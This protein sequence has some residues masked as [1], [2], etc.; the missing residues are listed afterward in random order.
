MA[1]RSASMSG[2]AS[3]GVGGRHDVVERPRAPLAVRAGDELLAVSGGQRRVRQQHGVA[4]GG[5]QP[6]VPPP[7]PGIPAAH[8]AAVHPKQQ[9]RL[10]VRRGGLGQHQPGPDRVAVV[11][12]RLDLLEPARHR[13]RDT[14]A[15]KRGRAR[16]RSFRIEVDAD[17]GGR[18][19]HRRPQ[20][21]QVP[22]VR[23]GVQVG[24]RAVVGGHPGNLAGAGVH[25]EH[26]PPAA[27]VGGEVQRAGVVRP[28]RVLAATGP[29]RAAGR[30]PARRPCSS[31]PRPSRQCPAASVRAASVEHDQGEVHRPLRRWRA[32]RAGRR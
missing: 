8:R 23:P 3:R 32:A 22:A 19:V 4:A 24:V 20:R 18:R 10:A 17:R 11:G 15:F 30:G 2:R 16:P 1:T 9:R 21:V 27:V 7:R 6:R 28:G 31:H 25:P 29:S 5:H 13:D 12:G 14:R 26:R